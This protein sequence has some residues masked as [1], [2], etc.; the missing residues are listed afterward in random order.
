MLA[1]LPKRKIAVGEGAELDIRIRQETPKKGL[2]GVKGVV[3]V[4]EAFGLEG[5]EREDVE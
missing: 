1:S 4:P 5:Y 3:E 2:E